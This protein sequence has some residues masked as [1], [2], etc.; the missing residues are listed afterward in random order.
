[1]KL[2]TSNDPSSTKYPR[3]DEGKALL[4][5][6]IMGAGV[7]IS[8]L[9]ASSCIR[10]AGKPMPVKPPQY[11]DSDGDG[12]LDHEDRCPKLAGDA[13][14]HGCPVSPRYPGLIPAVQNNPENSPA[15]PAPKSD[16]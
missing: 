11:A 1:M 6:V 15:P 14:N 12:V 8:G 13:K 2:K 4:R 9:T 16:N 7:V 10:T 3:Y 5:Q